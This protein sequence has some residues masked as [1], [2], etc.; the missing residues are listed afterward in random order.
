[1][2]VPFPFPH[3]LARLSRRFS[4]TLAAAVLAGCASTGGLQ[5][6]STLG[7]ANALESATSLE[8]AQLTPAAWPTHAWWESFGDAQ[9]DQLVQAA[10]AGQPGLKA[11][12]A[13]VRQADALAGVAGAPLYPQGVVSGRATRQRFSENSTTPQP[14]AGS[15]DWTADVQAGVG[16]EIDFWGKN[17]A[18]LDAALGRAQAADVDRHAAELMLTTSLV[19]AYLKLDAAYLLRDLAEQTLQQRE[20]TLKLTGSRVQAQLDS[21]LDMKQAEAALPATRERIAALNE[22]IALTRNQVAALTGQGP[23]AGIQIRRPAMQ[24][25]YVAAIPTA[26]P[27]DLIGRR[28]DVVAQRWRVEAASQEIKVARAQFYPNVSL[29][30]FAGV[31]SLGLS[32][33]LNAGSRVLGIGPAISL[34]V[35]DGGRLRG[36]LGARQAEYDVAVEQYNGTLITALH[37]VVDQIVSLRWQAERSAQQQQALVLTQEGYDMATAR[38]R[39]GVG[40]YLQVL[41]AES[42]VLQQKQLLI[43]LQTRGRALHLELIRALGGGYAPQAAQPPQSP[44]SL[45]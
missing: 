17:Q 2:Q 19:R 10:L 24:G 5:P 35:F 44:Q 18:A 12:A 9:L 16:Y 14:L 40:S 20:N 30:A 42:Q 36:N 39:N 45:S 3:P 33:L 1:M 22:Q 29:T 15:W 31:Q 37:D 8:G 32:D 7:T 13:R 28:P 21:R 25:D 34:P 4:L 27:A 6:Q 11:A 38:Y 23:D 43:E 26:V 41:S